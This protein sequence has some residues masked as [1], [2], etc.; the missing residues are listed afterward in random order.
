MIST[1]KQ[2]K[3][4]LED[5]GIPGIGTGI[6]H[7][8]I[9]N[10]FRFTIGNLKNITMQTTRVELDMLYSRVTVFV[11]QPCAMAQDF[12]DDIA[13]LGSKNGYVPEND[14]KIE[15]LDGC[16]EAYSSIAGYAQLVDHKL[17]LDYG[18]SKVAMHRLEFE[19]KRTAV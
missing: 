11:E 4:K 2:E 8:A 19:Y 17:V 9:A 6:L 16:G 12:I 3:L 13:R 10:R 5:F 14:M 1:A 18:D 7:P 15:F